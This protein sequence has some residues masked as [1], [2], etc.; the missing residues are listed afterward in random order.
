MNEEVECQGCGTHF[1]ADRG[2]VPAL[3]LR[4]VSPALVSFTIDIGAAVPEVEPEQLHRNPSPTVD[5]GSTP[6]PVHIG[7]DL[8]SWIPAPSDP[9]ALV[10]DLGCGSCPNMSMLKAA[11]YTYVPVDYSNPEAM[12][13][14]DAHA[15]PFADATFDFVISIAVLEHLHSPALAMSEVRRVL[16]PGRSMLGSVA[17]LEPYHSRSYY[18]HTQLG[19]ANSTLPGRSGTK[20]HLGHAQLDTVPGAGQVPLSGRSETA[21]KPT[22]SRR[23]RRPCVVVANRAVPSSQCFFPRSPRCIRS[24]RVDVPRR[25]PAGGRRPRHNSDPVV[26]TRSP[27]VCSASSGQGTWGRAPWRG[28]VSTY[29]AYQPPTSGPAAG[30][31]KWMVQRR[32]AKSR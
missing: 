24:R 27:P 9:G 19:L 23:L 29:P 28:G 26:A 12:M 6:A 10:L 14:C 20:T 1:K 5:F 11:G 8:M 3:D 22:H 31:L 25:F 2:Q 21:R 16:K 7:A 15:L 4:P 30:T 32:K 13:L 18:H 17:F